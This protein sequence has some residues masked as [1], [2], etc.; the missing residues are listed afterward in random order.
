MYRAP[1]SFSKALDL[2]ISDLAN[3]RYPTVHKIL[4]KIRAVVIARSWNLE[5]IYQ[6]AV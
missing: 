1:I 4:E 2:I 6:N 3:L 5:T